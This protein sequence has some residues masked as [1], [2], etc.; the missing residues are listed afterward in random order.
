MPDEGRGGGVGVRPTDGP[1]SARWI[2]A[3]ESAVETTVRSEHNG[4]G[5]TFG[6]EGLLGGR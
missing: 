6:S 3:A 4:H 2:G 5:R 1:A